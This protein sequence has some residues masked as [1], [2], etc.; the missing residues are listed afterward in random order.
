MAEPDI[1]QADWGAQ[2]T[3]RFVTLVDDVKAKTT[4]PLL[5]VIRALV[6]GVIILVVG[7]AA[8]V[9]LVVGLVRLVEVYLPG[10]IWATYLL[11]GVVF[12]LAGMF[13]WSKRT[14]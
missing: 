1:T 6:Y 3:D 8:V 5:K 4:G 9:L 13:A 7:L 12:V 2:A 11:L 10:E 14:P